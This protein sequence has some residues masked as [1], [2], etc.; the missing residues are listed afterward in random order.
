MS[1]TLKD[2][3][4]LSSQSTTKNVDIDIKEKAQTNNTTLN[5][6]DSKNL[7][8]F[9]QTPTAVP[10]PTGKETYH[11]GTTETVQDIRNKM[12]AEE[13][14][15]ANKMTVE[16][17]EDVADFII[18]AF[19]MLAVFLLRWYAMDNSDAPYQI[20]VDRLKKLKHRLS[21]LLMRM[22][23][24]FPLGFL[25]IIGL[26]LAYASSAKKA[27][28]HRKEVIDRKKKELAAKVPPPPPPT[29]AKGP[30]ITQ[31]V[32]KTIIKETPPARPSES[33]LIQR[34]QKVKEHAESQ[35]TVMPPKPRGRP[36]K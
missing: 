25:F 11:S 4:V 29:S 10:L 7:K 20:P 23:A 33:E 16:D 3:Q 36:S 5:F 1:E 32:S 34:A 14:K 15:E 27:K 30:K 12:L 31:E 6:L 13:E 8:Q 26:V 17:F 21:R 22:Q 18:D 24:K 2:P 19:D 28:D 35:A 9:V